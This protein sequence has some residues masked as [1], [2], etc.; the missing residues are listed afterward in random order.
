ML[1]SLKI[2]NYALIQELDID[3]T[4]GFSTLTGETGAGKSILLGAL[5]LALGNRADTSALNNNDKKCIIEACFNI[6]E[7]KLKA[8]FDELDIDFE[9]ETIIRREIGTSGKSRAFINDTPVNLNDLKS[10]S[11]RLIDIHSQHENLS[12]NDNRFQMTVL[13]TVA[14][15]SNTLN[16][17]KSKLIKYKS[18]IS[19]LDLLEEKAKNAAADSDYNQF[20]FNQLNEL[21]L[22]SINQD[23]I[24]KEL[25][26]LNNAEEIQSNLANAFQL[27]SNNESNVIDQLKQVK[28]AFDKIETFF[29][30]ADEFS[31]RVESAIIDLQ[32]ISSE[33]E[34][35]AESIEFNPN[36][37]I[38]LKEQLDEIYNLYQKHNTDNVPELVEIKNKLEEKLIQEVNFADDI[39]N[40]KDQILNFKNFLDALAT[41]LHDSRSKAIPKLC[42]NI[43]SILNELGMPNSGFE[44][45]LTLTDDFLSN[46]KDSIQFLFASNKKMQTQSINKIASGGEISRVMLSIKYI[47]SQSVALP[48]I[49]FDEIDTG[50]SGDIADKMGNIMQGMS[51]NMQVISI[52]HLPQIAAKGQSHYKVFKTEVNSHVE[53]RI[54][55]LNEKERID[56]LAKMLSGKNITPEAIENAKALITN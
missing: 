36:R 38:S 40:L 47:L 52:T 7:F 42:T 54:S 46:G 21:N 1:E 39:K 44:V 13:D 3:F 41:K 35:E 19:E 2:N 12:L 29:P 50:V 26:I 32:D 24:E 22:E 45:D 8:V 10:L 11:T 16:E 34:T 23:E 37:I 43:E 9:D 48:T 25:E 56:E 14:Q 33:T 4:K 6:S 28:T 30:K 20:Q 49:I 17:Y 18:L 55:K 5:G 31:K 27:L 51:K 53:T 15:N